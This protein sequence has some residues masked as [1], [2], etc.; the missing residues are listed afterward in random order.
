MSIIQEV[1][2]EINRNFLEDL[3][4]FKLTYQNFEFKNTG[5]LILS[6]VIGKYK[7]RVKYEF[8]EYKFILYSNINLRKIV[9]KNQICE[10][11]FKEIYKNRKHIL[12]D[13]IEGRYIMKD[14]NEIIEKINFFI[15]VC[16]YDK[17]NS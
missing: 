4:M 5:N 10:E 13:F 14:K 1:Y 11:N 2:E 9:N 16:K 8:P 6:L 7:M 15:G 3:V 12:D 17:N